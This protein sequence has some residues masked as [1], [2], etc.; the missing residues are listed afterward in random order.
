MAT[1]AA[2]VWRPTKVE[3][4][5]PTSHMRRMQRPTRSR[6]VA[7]PPPGPGRPWRRPTRPGPGWLRHRPDHP[8]G[9]GGR[10][11]PGGHV[12]AAC[13][14]P[15][16]R[17]V[18]PVRARCGPPA[19]APGETRTR[20]VRRQCGARRPPALLRGRSP[21]PIACCPSPGRVSEARHPLRVPSA[22]H[23]PSRPDAHTT[24]HVAARGRRRPPG[25]G[26]PTHTAE[27]SPAGGTAGAHYPHRQPP[28][29]G[30]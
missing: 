2:M 27:P 26:G 19:H 11:G 8:R 4:W 7:A 16:P 3:V 22:P 30:R 9:T 15:H 18:S 12:G 13:G 17:P 23:P 10:R 5:S 6:A 1:A 25:P 20:R 21:W 29:S 24:P 14:C 28:G